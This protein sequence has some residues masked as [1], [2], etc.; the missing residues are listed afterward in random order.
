[1]IYIP[2][3]RSRRAL[4]FPSFLSIHPPFYF[5]F[6]FFLVSSSFFLL[7]LEGVCFL[8]NSVHTSFSPC[9]RRELVSIYSLASRERE[10]KRETPSTLS[11]HMSYAM[12]HSSDTFGSL[13][14]WLHT[15]KHRLST[16]RISI[17][18]S[19]PVLTVYTCTYY[20]V[21][22][23][24]GTKSSSIIM[25]NPV[26]VTAN[27]NKREKTREREREKRTGWR[28]DWISP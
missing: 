10:R 3:C 9:N 20:T 5:Y 19:S 8:R 27:T 1:M 21:K 15:T 17:L 22:R 12:L 13:P 14:A 11:G 7:L 6:F 18:P 28:D 2:E 24:T 4:L 23:R 25:R 16:D 26:Y